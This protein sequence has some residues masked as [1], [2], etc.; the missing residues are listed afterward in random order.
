[1]RKAQ[2]VATVLLLCCGCTVFVGVARATQI[3]ALEAGFSPDQLGAPTTIDFGFRVS[4]PV[5]GA[6]PS[7]V[8]GVD[9]YLPAGMGLATSTLGLAVCQPRTLLELGLAGC[10]AN[11]RVGF[12]RALGELHVEGEVID[13]AA[14]V[15]AL[16]GPNV[17]GHEQVLFYVE[18]EAP[19][20]AELVFPG[21]LLPSTSPAFSGY[22]RT[23]VPIVTAWNDG[24]DI[25]VTR[26]SS[27]LGPR[28]L[29]YFRHVNGFVVPFKPRGI[30][31]P[32][33]CPAD[34]FMFRA[35]LTFLDGSRAIARHAVPC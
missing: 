9:L 2:L 14:R 6:I 1:M 29:T 30:A 26:F 35:D 17:N 5:P 28:G 25:S 11:A 13:E 8:V 33:S 23:S 34:G 32:T 16:L 22:L 31:V 24:P 15:Q 21:E 7:P 27:S 10:S 3:V 18:G 4:S 20:A 19:V 12:G